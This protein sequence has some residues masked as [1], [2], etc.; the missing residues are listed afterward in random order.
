MEKLVI[1][2]VLSDHEIRGLL[3]ANQGIVAIRLDN[4]RFRIFSRQP[5][6]LDINFELD[7]LKKNRTGATV[8]F[9]EAKVVCFPDF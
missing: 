3:P 7:C 6:R 2:Q 5:W 8:L 9:G 1:G 4:D